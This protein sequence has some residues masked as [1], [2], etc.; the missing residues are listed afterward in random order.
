[1][2]DSNATASSRHEA[3]KALY[4]IN[5]HEFLRTRQRGSA[6]TGEDLRRYI[7]PRIG[8]PAG[9]GSWGAMAAIVILSWRRR[10]MIENCGARPMV[11]RKSHGRL[12]P[13][14]RRPQTIRSRIRRLFSKAA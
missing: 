14:Y 2:D 5:A 13:A 12:T 4:Y 6:F 3:W 9:P 8:S 1:M 10:G 11:S 7:E